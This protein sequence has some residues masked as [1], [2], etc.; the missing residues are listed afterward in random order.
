MQL[1]EIFHTV[2]LG[3]GMSAG[4][5]G[6]HIAG[7]VFESTGLVM[8]LPI[9]ELIQSGRD[10]A[11]MAEE[12]RMWEILLAAYALVDLPVTLPVLLATSFVA[13][14]VRQA[15]VYL[16]HCYTAH[17]QFTLIRQLRD[18]AFRGFLV[19][20]LG[21]AED[22][23]FGHTINDL[24]VETQAAVN[25]VMNCVTG[26]GFIVLAAVYAGI[27]FAISIPMTAA[28]IA[29]VVA[30]VLPL[31][32]IMRRG[33][34]A[35]LER[36]RANSDMLYFLTERLKSIRLIRLSGTEV[37][38]L[39]TMRRHTRHQYQRW[40]RSARLQAGADVVVEP[41][42]V[43]A[44]L[45]FLYLAATR[46]GLAIEE[47]G[48]FLL[49]L[50]RLVPVVK[51]LVN[52]RYN[53]ANNMGSVETVKRRLERLEDG[54][55]PDAGSQPFPTLRKEIAF[56]R[57][58][59]RYDGAEKDALSEISI[60]LPAG[61]ITA[62]VGPSGA[63]KSSLVDLL[64]RLREPN[65]GRVTFDGVPATDFSL[66]SL[67]NAISYA[68]QAPQLFN[69]T[70]LEHIRYGRADAGPAEVA[71]AAR[72][73]GAHRFIETLDNG[74]DTIVGE[75]GARLSGGQRQRLDLARAILKN[76]PI[77]ILDEPTSQL[78]AESEHEFRC[79]LERIHAETN[80][81]IVIVGHRLS[82]VQVA[83][84]IV[85]LRNGRVADMGM[86]SDLMLRDGW[87]AG[88]VRK[89]QPVEPTLAVV[90]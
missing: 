49:I 67:R 77:L 30:A 1:R 86:H 36:V 76:A 32:G 72:L 59:F 26:A 22:G 55:E 75:S 34:R 31:A 13:I 66:E 64:P 33:R 29:V 50:V 57:V 71:R 15:L 65:A 87:Y 37:P 35:G 74:Y 52:V 2:G 9:F 82:T 46:F 18:R 79:A 38:E 14:L 24:T 51:E 84:K 20:R 25:M 61:A 4:V 44:A 6:L 80:M 21:R 48:V 54:R 23:E 78:D 43:A 73:A 5:L 12:S 85:V 28:A 83:E 89:Q 56:E 88:A 8:L 39:D 68:P 16:R 3:P 27:L 42:M 47:I 81:T 19:A 45:V 11:A 63:G 60:E 62:L 53:V 90:Q 17:V 40:M 41:I 10:A 70:V 69:V 7:T 58:T